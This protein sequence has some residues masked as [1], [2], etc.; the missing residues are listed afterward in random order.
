MKFQLCDMIS[1]CDGV[2][3][4]KGVSWLISGGRLC[5]VYVTMYINTASSSLARYALVHSYLILLSMFL[6][7]APL[8]FLYLFVFS[9]PLY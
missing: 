4:G 8:L 7:S 2:W 9:W 5:E 6:V 1:C 3:V